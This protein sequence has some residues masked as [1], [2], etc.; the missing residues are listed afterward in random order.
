MFFEIII[1]IVGFGILIKS[2]DW[3]VDGASAF[4]KKLNVSDLAIG[5]TIVAFGTSTPEL[6][7]NIFA[8]LENHS[9]IVLGNIIGSNNFNLFIILGTSA[10]ITPLIVQSSTVWKEIP[11]SLFAALLLL[12]LANNFFLS[13]KNYLSRIDG[14]ILFLMFILFV[15]YVYT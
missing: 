8:S 13:E 3:L 1:L 14:I 7:V 11:F 15:Y 4:A 12:F 9:D 2:A 5:L 6:V 10:L